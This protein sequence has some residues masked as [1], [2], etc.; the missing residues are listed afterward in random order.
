ML[1]WNGQIVTPE[2]AT[3]RVTSETALRGINA[4][5]GMRAYWQPI[6]QT[7][8]I[9]SFNAHLTR[10]RHSLALL[11]LPAQ[12][13]VQP[14]AAGALSVLRGSARELDYYLRPTIYLAE[15]AYTEAPE[16]CSFGSFVSCTATQSAL[17]PVGCF[18]SSFRRV[19]AGGTPPQAKSGAS[20]AMFRLARLEAS[21]HGYQEAV[22]LDVEGDVAETGGASVFIVAGET[23]ATPALS[24]A[25]LD[26][27]TRRHALSIL[28]DR[29]GRTVE[30]R[31]ISLDELR[32]A[33]EIFLTGTLDEIRPVNR[34]DSGTRP[35]GHAVTMELQATYL[36]ICRGLDEPVEPTMVYH[37]SPQSDSSDPRSVPA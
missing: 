28:R 4:F 5:E 21:E 8:A 13:L 37:V 35:L 24:D 29:L 2:T 17:P 30:E 9:V 11:R 7:F 18:V 19:A 33:D 10:L 3:V 15:G 36:R 26:S 27:I 6:S 1:W 23:A 25:L 31:P 20:Y 34:I 12:D 32:C 14:L 16:V 22:L